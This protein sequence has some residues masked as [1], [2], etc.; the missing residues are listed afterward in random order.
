MAQGHSYPDVFS[1]A[2]FESAV[3]KHILRNRWPPTLIFM[4]WWFLF[5]LSDVS[6]PI[7]WLFLKLSVQRIIPSRTAFKSL[8]QSEKWNSLYYSVWTA[9]PILMQFL[10]KLC[11]KQLASKTSEKKQK[12]KQQGMKNVVCGKRFD[13]VI[14]RTADSN[15][16][17][18]NTS[19]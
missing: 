16:A 3:Q 15:S 4:P 6:Q 10:E 17:A 14:F 13:K 7:L 12:K 5:F 18:E 1:A 19:G 2:E 11:V 8:V 9:D